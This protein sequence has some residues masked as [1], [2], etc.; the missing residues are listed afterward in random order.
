[1]G[2]WLLLVLIGKGGFI[3]ILLLNG[4]AVAVVDIV[5]TYRSRVMR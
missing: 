3:H 5:Y 4:I 1:M 2:I